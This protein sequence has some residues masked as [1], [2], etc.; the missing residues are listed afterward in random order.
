MGKSSQATA[1]IPKPKDEEGK[2]EG[3]GE[4]SELPQ[5]LVRIPV[6]QAEAAQKEAEAA[7]QVAGD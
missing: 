6:Q 7:A 1:K 5:T 3:A 4:K 2:D